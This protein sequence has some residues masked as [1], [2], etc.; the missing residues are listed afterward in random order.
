VGN[1][2]YY[3]LTGDETIR[4]AITPTKDWYMN[5]NTFRE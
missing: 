5:P 3:F 4:E 2:D 1:L